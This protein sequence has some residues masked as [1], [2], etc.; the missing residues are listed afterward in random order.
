MTRLLMLSGNNTLSFGG[1][2]LYGATDQGSLFKR[3]DVLLRLLVGAYW[4]KLVFIS[5]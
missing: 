4:D 1:N 2:L 3:L 5:S